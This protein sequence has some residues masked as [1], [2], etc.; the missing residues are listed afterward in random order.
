PVEGHDRP[1]E[2]HGEQGVPGPLEEAPGPRDRAHRYSSR[3]RSIRRVSRMISTTSTGKKIS[4]TAAPMPSRRAPSAVSY[5]RWG[6]I[7]VRLDGPP[8]VSSRTN[9]RLVAVQIV[10]SI[11]V[12]MKIVLRRGTVMKRNC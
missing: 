10:D 1:H 12:V 7:S 2:E 11:T 5:A 9:W 8:R 4:E 3:S 6:K